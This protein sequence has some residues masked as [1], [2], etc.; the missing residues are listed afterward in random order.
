MD[1]EKDLE[2]MAFA[3]GASHGPQAKAVPVTT[4]VGLGLQL[5]IA[6]AREAQI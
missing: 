6:M 1:A 3:G 4:A 2:K 5:T